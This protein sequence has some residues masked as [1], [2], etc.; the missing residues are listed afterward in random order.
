MNNN[1]I[2]IRTKKIIQKLVFY[3][4]LLVFMLKIIMFLVGI[5]IKIIRYIEFFIH[6]NR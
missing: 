1:K 2:S 5:W 3:A 4:K 6:T